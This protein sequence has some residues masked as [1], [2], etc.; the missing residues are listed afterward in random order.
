MY[1]C[2]LFVCIYEYIAYFRQW[3]HMYIIWGIFCGKKGI[4]LAHAPE[5]DAIF[6]YF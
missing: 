6:N 5:T 3:E 2:I 1:V 4:L